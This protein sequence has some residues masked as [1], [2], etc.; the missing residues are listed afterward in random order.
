MTSAS[1]FGIYLNASEKKVVRI[2]SPYWLP[3]EP[4]WVYV[5]EEVNATP[6]KIRD[7]IREASLA[8]DPDDVT[9][10]R[11]PLKEE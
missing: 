8:D 7:V 1:K 3:E 9:W 11:I 5:T 4:D 6:L 10:G 2:T